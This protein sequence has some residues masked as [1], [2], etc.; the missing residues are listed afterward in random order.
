M[1]AVF[2]GHRLMVSKKDGLGSAIVITW[3]AQPGPRLAFAMLGSSYPHPG[4]FRVGL[5]VPA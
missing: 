2:V 5:S 1:L 4:A 3:Q